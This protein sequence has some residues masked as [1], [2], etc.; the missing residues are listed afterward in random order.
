M[1]TKGPILIAT[2]NRHKRMK[3]AGI[4]SPLFEPVFCDDMEPVDEVGESFLEIAGNKAIEYS[5]RYGGLAISTDGGA[6]IPALLSKGW[7]PLRT[8]RFVDTE[9]DRERI[10]AVLRAM[11]GEENRTVEWHEAIAVAKD[12]RLLFTAQAKAMDGKISQSFDP[13]FYREG[14]WLCSITSFPQF[15]GR[16]F[17]E[18]SEE[19]QAATE[20]SWDLLKGEFLRFFGNSQ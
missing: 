9:D 20:D 6:V 13:R 18:L 1:G 15:G 3:L 4:V 19:E 5:K 7:D 12:G 14:I 2:G 11:N 10:G 17:F 8:R 16:N